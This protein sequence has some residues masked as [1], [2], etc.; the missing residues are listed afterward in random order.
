MKCNAVQA[1]ILSYIANSLH[2]IRMKDIELH[3]EECEECR[4]WYQDV[5]ELE[6]IWNDPTLPALEEDLTVAVMATLSDRPNPYRR[7]NRFNPLLK[8][9]LASSCALIL[10]ICNGAEWFDTAV[11]NIGNYNEH[12]ANSISDIYHNLSDN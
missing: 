6:R 2:S 5:L 9:A 10:F 4:E 3:L 12:I 7:N 8:M 1:N 11:S